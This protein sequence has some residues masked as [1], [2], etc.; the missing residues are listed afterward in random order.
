MSER[1]IMNYPFTGFDYKDIMEIGRRVRITNNEDNYDVSYIIPTDG[2]DG[3][4]EI[5]VNVCDD[6]IKNTLCYFSFLNSMCR[7]SCEVPVFKAIDQGLLSFNTYIDTI[8]ICTNEIVSGCKIC[9]VEAKSDEIL[10]RFGKQ[11]NPDDLHRL[12]SK[13][14]DYNYINGLFSFLTS[15]SY[16]VRTSKFKD[17][18]ISFD[19]IHDGYVSDIVTDIVN[20]KDD[21]EFFRSS[22]EVVYGPQLTKKISKPQV[23]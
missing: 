19:M 17:K 9:G 1:K 20:N 4:H 18:G 7:Y 14:E 8:L 16:V 23:I 5:S 21:I 15:D 12:H 11:Y 22:K 13:P 3:R 2:I 6:S 10:S